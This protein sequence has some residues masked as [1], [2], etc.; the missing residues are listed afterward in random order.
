MNFTWWVNRKDRDGR[1]IFEGGFLGL[2]NIGIFDRSAPLP[3]GGFMEQSDGTAWMAFYCQSMLQIALELAAEDPVYEEMAQKFIEHFLRIAGAMDRIGINPDELWDDEHGFFYD[4]LC[5]PNGSA[6]RIKVRS[7]VGLLPMCAC[8]VIVAAWDPGAL[9]LAQRPPLCS[10]RAR[11]GISLRV[12]A[13]RVQQRHVWR[14]LKL[15]RSGVDAH[16]RADHS[17]VDGA[18]P[19]LWE[20]FHHR[21]PHRIRRADDLV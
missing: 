2:D 15:A 14:Q 3:T 7:I 5:L 21:V 6:Q 10:E 17:R 11:R 9:S 19:V 8:T 20:R 18:L 1:N 4:V 16:Q 12:H 13:G